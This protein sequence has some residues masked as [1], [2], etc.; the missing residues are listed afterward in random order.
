VTLPLG[1]LRLVI[2][3]VLSATSLPKKTIGTV[4][5]GGGRRFND[6]RPTG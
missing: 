5:V 2:T 1:R 4:V 3:P 6:S